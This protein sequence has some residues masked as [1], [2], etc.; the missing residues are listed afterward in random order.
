MTEKK[1]MSYEEA[2]FLQQENPAALFAAEIEGWVIEEKDEDYERPIT[3]RLSIP[4]IC[5]LDVL[6]MRKKT[7]RAQ[8]MAEIIRIGISAVGKELPEDVRQEIEDEMSERMMKEWEN[9]KKEGDK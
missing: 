9:L 5:Y 8:V 4:G 2:G 1:K 6:A 7:S 3:C